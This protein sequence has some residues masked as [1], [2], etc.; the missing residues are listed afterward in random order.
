[1]CSDKLY[2]SPA[3]L[4]NYELIVDGNYG[5]VRINFGSSC[6]TWS[7]GLIWPFIF[8]FLIHVH[9]FH[10]CNYS[11]HNV[12]ILISIQLIPFSLFF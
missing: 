7:R 8:P 11:F 9:S 10:I 2:L 1:M 4:S 12:F 5:N 3:M 6:Y